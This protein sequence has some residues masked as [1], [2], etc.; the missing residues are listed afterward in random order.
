MHERQWDTPWP[1][2]ELAGVVA[3]LEFPAGS[4]ALDIGCGTG[5]DAVFLARCGL[6]VTG[7]DVSEAALELAE[8][9][10]RQAG[11]RVRWLV[12]DALDLP[13]DAESVDLA[14]AARSASAM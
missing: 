11:V 6:A 8:K 14:T 1:S 5:A 2:P 4:V 3:A 13:V 9:R 10:A 7:V 12:G